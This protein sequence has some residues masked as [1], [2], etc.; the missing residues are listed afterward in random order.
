[1]TSAFSIGAAA[2]DSRRGIAWMLLT[3][4]LFVSMDAIV[5]HLVLTYPVPQIA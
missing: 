2:H 3:M 5:K 4:L 1:M